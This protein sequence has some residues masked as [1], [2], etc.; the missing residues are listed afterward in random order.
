MR[1]KLAMTCISLF[2][3]ERKMKTVIK[4]SSMFI[5][6]TSSLVLVST[7]N[8]WAA[9]YHV[10]VG[11]T[12]NNTGADWTNAWNSMSKINMAGLNPGD[13]VYIAAGTYGSLVIT[14]S[15]SSGSPITFKRATSAEHGSS[16]G[17]SS[18][19]DGNVVIDGGNGLFAI[20]IG[21]GGDFLGKSYITIDGVTRYGIQARNAMYGIRADREG[22]SN[23]TFRYLELGD[24]GSYKL[25]E[26]GIQGSGNNLLVENCFIHDND[27]ITT[28]GDGIQWFSGNNFTVRY[29]LFKNNGQMFMLTETAWGNDY[30]TN[31]DISY[32]VFYNRGGSHYNGIS[33]KL[34]PPS[35][36]W[37][38]YNNTFDLEAKDDSGYNNIFSGTGSC[39]AMEFKNN[40]VIYSNAGSV[41]GVS[42]SYNAYD[43][44]GTYSVYEIPT[45]TGRVTAADLGFVNIAAA[46]YH[47][48]ATSPLIGKGVNLG[49]T[50]DFDGKAV[51]ATP[52]IGAFEYNSGGTPV[53]LPAP[54]NLRVVTP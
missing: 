33:K 40:A 6:L 4:K 22:N 23:L 10:R 18:A 32:N 27:N 41:G 7:A 42:H 25:G 1:I 34:C 53:T 35:G 15:G 51:P 17:W 50:R 49:Y 3:G 12:G 44:S 14:K 29:N 39:S 28:H 21:E 45:E 26:D 5:L 30:L 47:L 43:N 24:S 54:K 16:T 46:D 9:T 37:K 11:A 52:S 48:T 8:G 31:V 36:I 19:Y 38:I 20:G 13:T 2:V